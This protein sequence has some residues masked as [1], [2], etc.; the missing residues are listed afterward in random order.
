VGSDESFG[1]G[2]VEVD[3]S[4]GGFVSIGWFGLDGVYILWLCDR[5]NKIRCR[6]ME[7]WNCHHCPVSFVASRK[8]TVYGS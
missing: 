5:Y 8:L 6:K 3:Y 2:L 1:V 7:C 4:M